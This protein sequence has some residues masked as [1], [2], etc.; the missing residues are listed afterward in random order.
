MRIHNYAL[1]ALWR[2]ALICIAVVILVAIAI[3]IAA[4]AT[5]P[6]YV[7]AV[8]FA[9]GDNQWPAE[10]QTL[11]ASQQQND[12]TLDIAFV[13]AQ[14]EQLGCGYKIQG[15][16]YA[17]D[18]V[19]RKLLEG[20]KLYGPS[21][22]AESWPG[23][24]YKSEY[25]T[26]FYT[27]DCPVTV[28]IADPTYS[29][30][31]ATCDSTGTVSWTPGKGYSWGDYDPATVSNT[32]TTDDAHTLFASTGTRTF[33]TTGVFAEAQLDA[34]KEPCLIVPPKPDDKVEYSDWVDEDLT[35]D[36][37]DVVQHR[38]RTETTSTYDATTN[39]W[40]THVQA[41]AEDGTRSKTAA[42]IEACVPVPPVDACPNLD[43]TQATVPDGYVLEDG[44]CVLVPVVPVCEPSEEVS[45][46]MCV[47]ADL[48]DP[49]PSRLATTGVDPLLAG[50]VA[51]TLL[52]GGLLLLMWKRRPRPVAEAIDD[53][54]DL[55][56]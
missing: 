46:G 32:A 35:C 42:E 7:T 8:W 24:S 49:D 19:T 3:P 36:R 27:G 4:Q 52:A 18:K 55:Y 17:N 41:F 11:A 25:S 53:H 14:A 29:T 40:A 12:K 16:L 31:P 10:G 56:L 54:S 21:N 37:E 33:T 28:T 1:P 30:T 34:T 43:G 23:G 22:P 6:S 26:V 20:G 48:A 51:G 47:P 44:S 39:S 38:T 50:A 2:A 13:K 15:D 5:S 45:N 9:K